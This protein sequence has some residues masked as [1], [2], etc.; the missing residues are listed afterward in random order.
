[1]NRS[2]V[3]LWDWQKVRTS[4]TKQSK[5]EIINLELYLPAR[6]HSLCCIDSSSSSWW[7]SETSSLADTKRRPLATPL[8]WPWLV[9]TLDTPWGRDSTSQP[10]S[11]APMDVLWDRAISSGIPRGAIECIDVLLQELQSYFEIH[12]SGFRQSLPSFRI[13]NEFL[14]ALQAQ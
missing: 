1:M 9:Q 6:Y 7:C 4:E 2:H 12:Q 5:A 14:F 3:V 11:V 8:H 13:D 10:P